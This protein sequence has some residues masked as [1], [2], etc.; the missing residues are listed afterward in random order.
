M[1]K[2]NNSKFQINKSGNEYSISLADITASNSKSKL[3]GLLKIGNQKYRRYEVTVGTTLYKIIT[4]DDVEDGMPIAYVEALAIAQET[5]DKSSSFTSLLDKKHANDYSTFDLFKFNIN[6]EELIVAVNDQGKVI[7]LKLNNS[8]VGEYEVMGK[9]FKNYELYG[10]NLNDSIV[11]TQDGGV[12][13]NFKTR[14]AGI[15]GTATDF[16]KLNDSSATDGTN[17]TNGVNI[18]ENFSYSY[19][20][21]DVYEVSKQESTKGKLI[22]VPSDSS[23]FKSSSNESAKVDDKSASVTKAHFKGLHLTPTRFGA[24]DKIGTYLPT[25][26]YFADSIKHVHDKKAQRIKTLYTNLIE[27]ATCNLNNKIVDVQ[28]Y[29]N[30]FNTKTTSQ[31]KILKNKI[32]KNKKKAKDLKKKYQMIKNSYIAM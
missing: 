32:S 23:T 9:I 27:R 2:I 14:D 29:F 20:N 4:E 13:G 1:T 16:I 3:V 19:L 5:H 6:S 15:F 8:A 18:E 26:L 22:P 21:G 17:V 10:N 25:L 31:I 30:D 28:L 11:L 7:Q 24:D 12:F